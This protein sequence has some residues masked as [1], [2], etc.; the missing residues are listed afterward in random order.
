MGTTILLNMPNPYFEFSR[1]SF[2]DTVTTPQPMIRRWPDDG[3]LSG[4]GVSDTT[5]VPAISGPGNHTLVYSY[6][7]SEGQEYSTEIEV[8][9]DDC[10]VGIEPREL[11]D[12]VIYP[13]P[14]STFLTI[15][16]GSSEKYHIR[17]N[18]LNGQTI[19]S[20]T[21][22]GT[23]HQIDLSSFQKGVYF[24]TIKSNDFVTTE[25]IIKL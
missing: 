21:M 9:V 14:A 7:S 23:S 16:T 12:I 18:S 15:E 5:F 20:T 25:K 1:T 2:C 24:I 4:T 3:T 17:I 13:N 22:E 6:T 19:L 8:I 11:Q 10:S